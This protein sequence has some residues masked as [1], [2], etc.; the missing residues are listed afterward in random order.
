MGNIFDWV[1]D[2]P[3]EGDEVFNQ[4]GIEIIMSEKDMRKSKTIDVRLKEF[5]WGHDLTVSS[6]F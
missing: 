1:Q 5:P 4:D 2:E 3:K 6:I